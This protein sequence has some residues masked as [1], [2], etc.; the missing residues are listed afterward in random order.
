M[1]DDDRVSLGWKIVLLLIIEEKF[2]VDLSISVPVL[3]DLRTESERSNFALVI[4]NGIYARLQHN[5][6]TIALHLGHGTRLATVDT[7]L[8]IVLLFLDWRQDIVRFGI[9]LV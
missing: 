7:L 3:I 4:G 5:S 9:E 1:V 8:A 2:K 6:V